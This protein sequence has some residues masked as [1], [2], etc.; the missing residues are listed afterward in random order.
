MFVFETMATAIEQKQLVQTKKIPIMNEIPKICEE[1]NT[2]QESL[3][4]NINF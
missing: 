1:I 3:S 4:L 2:L